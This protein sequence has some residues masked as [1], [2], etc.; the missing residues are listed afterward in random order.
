MYERKDGTDYK[1]LRVWKIS[2]Q[3][4]V[5]KVRNYQ[6]PRKNRE[7]ANGRNLKKKKML[8]EKNF[9][10]FYSY[11]LQY[12]SISKSP[13]LLPFKYWCK[14]YSFWL[15]VFLQQLYLCIWEGFWLNRCLLNIADF[16]LV[17]NVSFLRKQTNHTEIERK[18]HSN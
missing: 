9:L 13:S 11:L 4:W 5:E 3:V 8:I 17:K 16:F 18:K 12:V 15:Q 7:A 6:W 1:K 2:Q 14:N 10:L